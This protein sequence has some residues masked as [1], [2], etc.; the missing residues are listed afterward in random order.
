VL[1]KTNTILCD[2]IPPNMFVAASYAK[3][4]THSLEITWAN[5]G[6]IYPFLL[7]STRPID[8]TEYPS[9]LETV[10]QS[11]PLGVNRVVAYNDQRLTLLPGDTIMFYTDGVIEA[12]N[13]AREM[14]GFERLEILVRSLPVHMMPQVL[15]EAVL[16]DVARFVGPAEP[17]DDMTIVVVKLAEK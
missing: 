12:M 14:Y 8:L 13:S 10:G 1:N 6:Q 17:H 5:A 4:N 15:I 16:A 11:L 7:H 3:L 2:S 9:Y